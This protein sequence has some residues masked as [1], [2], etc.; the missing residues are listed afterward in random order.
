MAAQFADV[1]QAVL[2]HR[3]SL[4]AQTVAGHAHV[5]WQAHRQQ[6]LRSEQTG[7]A[8]LHPLLQALV[9][10]E[11]LHARLCVRVVGRLELQLVHA[12]LLEELLDGAHQIAQRHVK[13]GHHTFDLEEL[14]KMRGVQR[15]VTEHLVDAEQLHRL[16][17]AGPPVLLG[18]F[19][20]HLRAAGGRVRS[21]YVLLR[22]AQS[23]FGLVA[24]RAVA[25]GAVHLAD[26]RAVVLRDVLAFAGRANEERVLCLA[27]RVLL[28]HE[29]R[30]EVPERA[31]H[32][33][34]GRHLAEAHL[35]EDLPVLLA[36]LEQRMQM[37]LVRHHTQRIEVVV[38][39]LLGLPGAL[40]DHLRVQVGLRFLEVQR[41]RLALPDVEALNGDLFDQLSFL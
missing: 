17:H 34:A 2:D 27:R 4:Q 21:Q 33:L 38:L 36:H 12:E 31:L 16:E 28:R 25:A 14:R 8:D 35:Q 19:V 40:H 18:G 32:V 15:L 30:V 6:H 26:R 10:A 24:L 41:E 20:E 13:A 29:Q 5:L 39:E 3:R 7:I 11:D 1:V 23:P 22:L 9:V 37:T